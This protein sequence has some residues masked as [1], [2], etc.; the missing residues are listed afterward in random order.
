MSHINQDTPLTDRRG[1]ALST[2]DEAAA[3]YREGTD[4]LLELAPGA[5]ERLEA[6]LAADPCFLVAHAALA[7]AHLVEDRPSRARAA[8][9]GARASLAGAPDR[10]DADARERRHFEIIAAGVAGDAPRALELAREHAREAP[11]DVLVLTLLCA[12]AL[13]GDVKLKLEVER[14]LPQVAPACR[15]DWAFLSLEAAHL[16]DLGRHDEALASALR[17][18]ALHPAGARAAHVLAHVRYERGEHAQGRRFLAWWLALWTPA[19]HV[20][21]HLRWHEGLFALALAERGAA[22]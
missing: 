16:D 22:L 6:A 3:H 21:A 14:L 11:R 18:L 7:L 13:R 12:L 19:P 17:A 20:L 1:L 8:V 5:V 4:R 9:L 15:D 10:G 2:G